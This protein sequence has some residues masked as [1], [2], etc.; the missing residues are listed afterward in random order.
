MNSNLIGSNI[1]NKYGKYL[2]K[3]QRQQ[4]Q[5]PRN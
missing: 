4:Q 2:K 5:Q 3:H 1:E